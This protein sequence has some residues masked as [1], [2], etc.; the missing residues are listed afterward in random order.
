MS[1]KQFYPF[2]DFQSDQ[3]QTSYRWNIHAHYACRNVDLNLKLVTGTTVTDHFSNN[4]FINRTC[5]WGVRLTCLD[6]KGRQGVKW[7]HGL[8]GGWGEEFT[9]SVW[10]IRSQT[11]CNTYSL[12]SS[13][14]PPKIRLMNLLFQ[15]WIRCFFVDFRFI[16]AFLYAYLAVNWHAR[17]MQLPVLAA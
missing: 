9:I 3:I 2:K 6:C 14:V 15:S 7:H 17:Y 12:S 8:F 13:S 1:S 11:E 4:Q 5:C 10:S 16:S